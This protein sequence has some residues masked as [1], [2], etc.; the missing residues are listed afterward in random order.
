MH[1]AVQQEV[2]YATHYVQL[3]LMAD[4]MEAVLHAVRELA[5]LQLSSPVTKLVLEN[6]ETL[7]SK[8]TDTCTRIVTSIKDKVY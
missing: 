1:Y 7:K 4:D 5:E 6:I 8:H 2:T 3:V